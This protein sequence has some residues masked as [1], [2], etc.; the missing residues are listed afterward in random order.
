MDYIYFETVDVDDTEEALKILECAQR[1]E[2][3]ELESNAFKYL[4][5][6][7]NEMNC[8]NM[9]ADAKRLGLHQLKASAM[10]VLAEHFHSLCTSISISLLDAN[11]ME[12]LVKSHHLRIQSE[13]NVLHAV[14][15]WLLLHGYIAELNR[16][17]QDSERQQE[18]S[19]S[20]VCHVVNR[21]TR[22]VDVDRFNEPELKAAVRQCDALNLA[23]LY[24][25]CLKI[26]V[27]SEPVNLEVD[28][29]LAVYSRNAASLFGLSLNMD[30]N[31]AKKR[32][33]FG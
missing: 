33:L 27:G 16:L 17:E 26:L 14:A 12:E 4:E 2:L 7:I 6:T 30:S 25:V 18:G 22:L 32:S 8:C 5:F 10:K 21:M 29:N 23:K 3:S 15:K 24:D 13:L 11:N 19:E 20:G 28:K 9:A 31:V 1:F